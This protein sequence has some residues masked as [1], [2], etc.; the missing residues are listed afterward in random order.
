MTQKIERII[1]WV[2]IAIVYYEYVKFPETYT[3]YRTLITGEK[4]R[5]EYV[6]NLDYKAKFYEWTDKELDRFNEEHKLNAKVI[7]KRKMTKGEHLLVRG[8]MKEFIVNEGEIYC[9]CI[10]KDG[11]DNFS[12]VFVEIVKATW[13]DRMKKYAYVM[14]DMEKKTQKSYDKGL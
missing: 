1:L 4:I 12:L 6:C 2:S 8:E 13:G 9:L 10:F 3:K 14:Y 11:S 7:T 5:T